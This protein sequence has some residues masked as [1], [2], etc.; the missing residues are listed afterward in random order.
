MFK[1]IFFAITCF[2]LVRCA[3]TKT[4]NAD[5]TPTI[6]KLHSDIQLVDDSLKLYYQQ[7]MNNQIESVPN[8]AI[9]KT[10]DAHLT[11]YHFYPKNEFSAECLDKVHQLYIQQKLYV[12]SVEIADTLLAEFPKYKGKKDVLYSIATTYDF[13]LNDTL[14]AKKYYE[15]MLAIPKLDKETR[16][17]IAARIN[18][19]GMSLDEM[20]EFQN[21]KRVKK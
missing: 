19:M 15:K 3:G 12:K 6:E 13:M 1:F 8:E 9:Q 21:K 20:I 16:E 4:E 14:N 7:V 10:I 18:L 5:G 2:C 11:F 17:N